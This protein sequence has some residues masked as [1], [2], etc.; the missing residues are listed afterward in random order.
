LKALGF[1]IKLNKSIFD[2]CQIIDFLGLTFNLNSL[3]LSVPLSKLKKVRS[4]CRRMLTS[5][6][7]TPPK[8]ASLLGV[9]NSV[10]NATR[11]SRFQCQC[12]QRWLKNALSQGSWDK[13]C[14]L[15]ENAR[16]EQCYSALFPSKFN[17]VSTLPRD[18]E[19]KSQ[20]IAQTDAFK[21]GW[22]AVLP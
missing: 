21:T 12:L 5:P 11:Y 16:D 17:G 1:A 4:N 10:C 3:E 7:T 13:G 6:K 9:L 8:L 18:V 20:V 15:D 19:M 2:P 14:I 22:G